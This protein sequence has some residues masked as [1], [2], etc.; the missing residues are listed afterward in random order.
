MPSMPAN[1]QS[2]DRNL[3][4]NSWCRLPTL[5]M[6]RSKAIDETGP[7]AGDGNVSVAVTGWNPSNGGGATERATSGD[8]DGGSEPARKS[9]THWAR[10]SIMAMV[11]RRST[12]ER[13]DEQAQ[14]EGEHLMPGGQFAATCTFQH[15][16]PP[17]PT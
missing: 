10:E 13:K 6:F 8:G 15:M 14:E 3:T 1:S 11:R 17:Q 12:V 16:L 7:T 5:S 9:R 4:L 2:F